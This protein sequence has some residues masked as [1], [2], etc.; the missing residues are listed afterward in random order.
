MCAI[1]LGMSSKE[2]PT[3]C[4]CGVS[5][6]VM[7][8]LAQEKRAGLSEVLHT[9]ADAVSAEGCI[10]WQETPAVN[11]LFVLADW[12]RGNAKSFLH[13]LSLFHSATG[14]AILDQ[15]I[16]TVNDVQ[17]DERVDRRDPFFQL[18]G[19]RCFCSIPLSAIGG[20]R[21]ALNVY[22]IT[23][24]P[25]QARELAQLEGCANLLPS[26]YQAITDRVSYRLVRDIN[27]ILQEANHSRQRSGTGP[28][29]FASTA[30]KLCR[31][32]AET[33]DAMEVS[34][35]LE[36][37]TVEP[38]AFRVAAT[39][40]PERKRF[41]KPVYRAREEEGL[42][43]WVLAHRR[44]V[45]IFDLAHFE[46]ERSW[47]HADY[48]G[49]MWRDSLKIEK[50]VRRFLEIRPDRGLQPLSFM[51][52]P[53][54]ATGKL[55]GV[56]RCCTAIQSP[57]YFGERE[58]KL[59]ELVADQIGQAWS[60][61]LH[62]REI[63]EEIVTWQG[64]AESM[65][66]LNLFVEKQVAAGNSSESQ[67]FQKALEV[68]NNVIP[69]AEISDVRLLD[70]ENRELYF[71]ATCG[72]AW[73]RGNQSLIT[74]RKA[75]R[76]G[77]DGHSGG[78][79]VMRTGQI[80]MI[81]DTQD[82]RYHYSETFIDTRSV[83]IAPISVAG[84]VLGVL[85]VRSTGRREFPRYG[86]RVAEIVSQQLGL[87]HYLLTTFADLQ[88]FQKIQL[89]TFEDFTHQLKSPI[90]QVHAR[91]QKCLRLFGQEASDTIRPQLLAIRGLAAKAENVIQAL[92]LFYD[93]ASGRLLRPT[94]SRLSLD[95]VKTVIEA[96]ADQ[97]TIVDPD[98]QLRF[99]VDREGFEAL[100][101][102]HVMAD[103]NLLLQALNN[104][105]DNAAKY[106]HSGTTVRISAGLT[107]TGRFYIM[108]LNQGIS[109]ASSEVRLC[110]KR[111]WRSRRAS[112]VTGEGSGIG[113]WIVDN[114]MLSHQGE[115]LVTPTS[116]ENFTEVRLLFPTVLVK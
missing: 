43:G 24:E 45:R 96:A 69:G 1:L 51:A 54:L 53:V 104:L 90:L 72:K 19:I 48:P 23:D 102:N 18:A 85:D 76:F 86:M 32:V 49:L 31:S 36:D 22:R 13:N 88:G 28:S 26:L 64:L 113:L 112:E 20:R 74:E 35:F 27:R 67:I 89:Q 110:K 99:H 47:L 38:K 37:P 94:L 10:L 82:P 114:I 91:T 115:L 93:L 15:E 71:A 84:K 81:A 6:L 77:L 62:R 111:A 87:Y 60:H 61:W 79:H 100:R 29:T 8:A 66:D 73:Q 101:S 44:S 4:S 39:T 80:Y 11:Q 5:D 34:L 25:F 108:V 9:V 63:E 97:E 95:F 98:Q 57:Y 2:P 65:R 41:A 109:L 107:T 105:L 58:E 103:Q 7:V 42:T 92:S 3:A 14:Q 83:I 75:R 46:R 70:E 17:S 52:A 21:G 40:W 16:V 116:P 55:L 50:S 68:T 12:F 33:F 30:R 106:S 78:A 59:L 56:I